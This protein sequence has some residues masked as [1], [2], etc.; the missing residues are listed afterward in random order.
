MR[1]GKGQVIYRYLPQMLIDYNN[2]RC[3]AIVSKWDSK[4]ITNIAKRRILQKIRRNFPKFAKPFGFPSE[5]EENSYEIMTPREIEVEVFPLTLICSKCGKAVQFKEAKQIEEWL[6]KRG[7]T[8]QCKMNGCNGK[9]MQRDLVYVHTCGF[10]DSL[11]IAKCHQHG[12]EFIKFNKKGS[13]SIGGRQATTHIQAVHALLPRED[14]LQ[15]NA[16][17]AVG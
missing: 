1:R 4:E 14:R 3:I 11:N 15:G 2:G 6:S 13:S 12:Y 17:G 7:N 8:Y 5:N 16:Q 9:F 10:Y